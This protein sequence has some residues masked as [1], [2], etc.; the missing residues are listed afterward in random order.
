MF[1]VCT[2]FIFCIN[3]NVISDQQ[4][5]FDYNVFFSNGF[6]NFFFTIYDLCAVIIIV[7]LLSIYIIKNQRL[8]NISHKVVVNA[9]SLLYA[10]II[11]SLI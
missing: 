6:Y 1:Y 9:E 7:N 10:I 5:I 2:L 4:K 3:I 8:T 11:V